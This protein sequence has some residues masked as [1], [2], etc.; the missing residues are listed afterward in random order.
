M[1][2]I[3]KLFNAKKPQLRRCAFCDK[4]GHNKSTC[5]LF[6]ASKIQKVQVDKPL[7]QTSQ[8]KL[9]VHHVSSQPTT[10]N[11]VVNLKK[12]T[13][14]SW[15]EVEAIA[16]DKT[17]NYNF[18][19]AYNQIKQDSES[20]QTNNHY[21]NQSFK[22]LSFTRGQEKLVDFYPK[23]ISNNTSRPKI[24]IKKPNYSN[25]LSLVANKTKTAKQDFESFAQKT[26]LLQK[27]G[28]VGLVMF[29]IFVL[30][31][32][33]SSYFADIKLTKDSIVE[34]STMGFMSLENSTAALMQADFITAQNSMNTAL[35]S[36]GSAVETMNNKHELLQKIL[37][38]VPVLGGEV[39]SRQALLLAGQQIAMG[40]KF[41]ID[42]LAQNQ[43][44][45]SSTLSARLDVLIANLNSAIPNYQ[46]AMK[47]LNTVDPS[48]LPLNY[49]G[50][51]VE[52]RKL[53]SAVLE[54]LNNLRDL[55]GALKEVFGAN[56]Q[57]RYLLVFQNPDEIRPTGGF[58]GSIAV[59][60][61][62]DGKIINMDIPAGGSYDL[63]GQ[64]NEYLIPPTPLLL[65][66]KR[67]EFQDSNWFPD[68]KTSA[69]KIMWFYRHS[70]SVTTDGVI[71]INSSVLTRL[72]MTLGPVTDQK[73]DLTIS[74]D[75]AIGT[76]QTVVENGAEKSE[77]KPKQIISDLA[78]QFIDQIKNLDAKKLLPLL[79]SL[80]EALNQK[81]IQAYFTDGQAQNLME[82]YGWSGKILETRNNQDY[83]NVVNT[84]IQGQKSDAKIKQTISHEAVIAD[85][86]SIT[87]TVTITRQHTG[88]NNENLYG[89][90]NIDYIRIYVPLGSELTSASGFIWPD[91]S[92]FKVPE[93]FYQ[94][95]EL[96]SS[97]EQEIKIDPRTGTRIT[98][99]FNK[100]AFGNWVIT[101]P[102][103]ESTIVFSYKLPFGIKDLNANGQSFSDKLIGRSI[104]KY[105]L[106]VQK[107]S[108]VDSAF[109]S[110]IIFPESWEPNYKE[111][112]DLSL[113]KN[114]G[115]IKID[116][117]K[118]D[119][120][121]GL[122]MQK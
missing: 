9:F 21:K 93:N 29:F 27:A 77:N 116:N 72:L 100:T 11:H 69:E 76:I 16:P 83:I 70:R 120:I 108:G 66:N 103:E 87:N 56:G 91:E 23:K 121:W 96:L 95:D 47:N 114:G 104:A 102:G 88:N 31:N 107:Q 94:T 1:S 80:H 67:W 15:H 37:S 92:H 109:E 26:L 46:E 28:F 43:T 63:Q 59:M 32:T 5:Q 50:P 55:S 42:G 53:F 4:A 122:I 45:T 49:Q 58:I 39:K 7:N 65:S 90:P 8:I 99:E 2:R 60:D 64:L 3:K 71:A 110:Q 73:R 101:S 54:D 98:K 84:N 118:T 78:P 33:A 105:Q 86:G 14:H 74:A 57:R 85:D 19:K 61:V 111:G 75:N 97:V 68:F 119:K 89:V 18:S 22:A 51:F 112:D 79:S 44:D 12:T 20:S 36:F 6:L 41:L 115:S 81:E 24:F 38:V 117:L 48:S 113:A 52:F 30:P 10:S 25:L 40:N 13:D 34:D 17:N 82:Q 62:K 106:I 35:N